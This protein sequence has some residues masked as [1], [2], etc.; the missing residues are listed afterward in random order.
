MLKIGVS[1][2]VLKYDDPNEIITALKALS[3]NGKY[4]SVGLVE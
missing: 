2:Y 3:N 1:N 4:F